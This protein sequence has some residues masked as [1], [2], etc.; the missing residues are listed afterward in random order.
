MRYL[1]AVFSLAALLSFAALPANAQVKSTTT[2]T[3]AKKPSHVA[4]VDDAMAAATAAG[5][6]NVTGLAQKGHGAFHGMGTPPGGTAQ[7]PLTV[8]PSGKVEQGDTD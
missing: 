1:P 2:T 4:T 6:T 7:V 3:V 5:W 8:T